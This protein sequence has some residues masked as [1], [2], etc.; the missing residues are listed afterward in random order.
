MDTKTT[1]DLH[2]LEA[3]LKDAPG[4]ARPSEPPTLH[5]LVFRKG[6]GLVAKP[7]DAPGKATA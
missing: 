4:K 2:S 1:A 5:K 3:K 6:E 7:K